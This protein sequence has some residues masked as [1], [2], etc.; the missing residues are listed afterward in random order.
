M[1]IGAGQADAVRAL[2]E[3]RGFTAIEI[4]RD[5]GKIERVV[6]GVRDSRS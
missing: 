4:A 5:Y 2:F 1:E 3:A 6:S